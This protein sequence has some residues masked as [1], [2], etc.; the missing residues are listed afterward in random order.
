MPTLSGSKP[1]PTATTAATI[2]QLTSIFALHGLLEVIVTDNGSCFTS[3]EC[4]VFTKQN[5]IRH[6]RT[7]PYHPTSNGQAER[8]VK[9]VKEGLK[10]FQTVIR[11][12]PQ[13]LPC[14]HPPPHPL[15]NMVTW[16]LY[17]PEMALQPPPPNIFP[18]PID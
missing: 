9:V 5:G 7:T 8:V 16:T 6:N 2:E 17:K 13:Q 14:P 11:L 4:Q 12:K 3:A 10:S 15:T 18:V 1:V